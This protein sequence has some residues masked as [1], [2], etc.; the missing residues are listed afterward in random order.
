MN[1]ATFKG[2]N[3]LSL[4]ISICKCAVTVIFE[5]WHTWTYPYLNTV[6]QENDTS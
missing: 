3:T 6:K 1:A 2:R 4:N 5:D